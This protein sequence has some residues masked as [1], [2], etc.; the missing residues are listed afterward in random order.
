MTFIKWEE[1]YS[2]GIE[3]IDEQH[4]KLIE[5][6]NEFYE[7]L[8]SDKNFALSKL[9]SGLE[10]Y[11]NSHF[12]FEEKYFKQFDYPKSQEHIEEH[13]TF[14]EKVNA[15]KATFQSGKS[16]LSIE[17][18]MFLRNWLLYHIKDSDKQYSDFFIKNGLK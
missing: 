5:L 3:S 15:F 18:A 11:A 2:L 10:E 17:L 7:K 14:F 4:K 12:Q 16:V 6:I 13:E 1:G 9:L 8:L